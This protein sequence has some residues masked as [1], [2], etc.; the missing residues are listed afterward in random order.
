MK[1]GKSGVKRLLRWTLKSNPDCGK[2]CQK[3]YNGD[4]SARKAAEERLEAS[5]TRANAA[6]L[7]DAGG[8]VQQQ[9]HQRSREATND[10]SARESPASFRAAAFARVA[11]ASNLSSAALRALRS[12]L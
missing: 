9:K 10:S 7:K 5:A 1:V 4:L 11:E 8:S 6:A 12:P 2:V 3:C